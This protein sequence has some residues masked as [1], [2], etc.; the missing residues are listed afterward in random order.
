[1]DFKQ[2]AARVAFGE[3]R[4]FAVDCKVIAVAHEHEAIFLCFDGGDVALRGEDF[5]FGDLEKEIDGWR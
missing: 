5:E 4:E 2:A 3:A 1:M